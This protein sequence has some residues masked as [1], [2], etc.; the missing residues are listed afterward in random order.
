MEEFW[1]IPFQPLLVLQRV[2]PVHL[3]P[4]C[5]IQKFEM[6]LHEGGAIFH[7]LGSEEHEPEH[8]SLIP[9][10]IKLTFYSGFS[11][12]FCGIYIFRNCLFSFSKI[13]PV[14][15]YSNQWLFF[16]NER[17][18]QFDLTLKGFDFF[19]YCICT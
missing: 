19:I 9:A 14:I 16:R 15:F 3:F 4:I 18:E 7:L 1:I 17:F 8:P 11:D 12:V 13:L 10:S 5:R 6:L 2:L